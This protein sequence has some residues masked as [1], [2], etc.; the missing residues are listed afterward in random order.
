VVVVV[1]VAVVSLVI[2]NSFFGENKDHIHHFFLI[3][4]VI[5]LT[6]GLA[7]HPHAAPALV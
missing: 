2:L 4:C 6:I 7:L 5:H 1:V 3:Q